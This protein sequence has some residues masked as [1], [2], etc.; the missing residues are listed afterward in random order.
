MAHYSPFPTVIITTIIT[1]INNIIEWVNAVKRSS[2]FES[3]LGH[4]P[5]IDSSHLR[6]FPLD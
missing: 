2:V 3:R 5:A 4:V 1:M 6:H